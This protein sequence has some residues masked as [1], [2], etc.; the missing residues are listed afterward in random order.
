ML[1]IVLLAS[2]LLNVKHCGIVTSMLALGWTTVHSCICA[3]TLATGLCLHNAQ[4]SSGVMRAAEVVVDDTYTLAALYGLSNEND[5]ALAS[6][7]CRTSYI[8]HNINK[9]AAS[10]RN[11]I[12]AA[13]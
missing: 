3:T 5:R 1:S 4:H 2:S 6:Q 12:L 8:G 13:Q 11:Y 7:S 9:K 10:P